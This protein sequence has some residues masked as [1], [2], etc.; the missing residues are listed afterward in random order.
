MSLI[1]NNLY[2]V[3]YSAD[4]FDLIFH[5]KKEFCS[6]LEEHVVELIEKKIAEYDLLDESLDIPKI[7]QD[8][9]I[10]LKKDFQKSRN[11][12]TY[13]DESSFCGKLDDFDVCL[14]LYKNRGIYYIQLFGSE[15]SVERMRSLLNLTE[16]VS[17]DDR[18]DCGYEGDDGAVRMERDRK[19]IQEIFADGGTP[20]ECGL[21]IVIS[22]RIPQIF[23]FHHF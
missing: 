21:T 23:C 2:R 14:V 10:Q 17:F 3:S 15:W 13:P 5:A 1:V 22:D 7:V 20:F 12:D 9:Y 8:F 19:L 4:L 6:I 16:D 11:Q 18:S